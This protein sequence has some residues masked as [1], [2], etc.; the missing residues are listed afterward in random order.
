MLRKNTV[1]HI[2]DACDRILFS[3]DD[4]DDI[5]FILE[6]VSEEQANRCYRA[7]LTEIVRQCRA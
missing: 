6:H 1:I 3:R 5:R 7:Y 2:L 4:A